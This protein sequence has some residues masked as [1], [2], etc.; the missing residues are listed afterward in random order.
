LL[1]SAGL[2]LERF[3]ELSPEPSQGKLTVSLWLGLKPV[4]AKKK[5]L[6][7]KVEVAA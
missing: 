6:G 7:S 1:E 4:D 2:K 3:A 5:R